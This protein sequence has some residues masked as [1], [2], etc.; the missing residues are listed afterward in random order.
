VQRFSVS[1]SGAVRK[2]ASRLHPD[3]REYDFRASGMVVEPTADVLT[4]AAVDVRCAGHF[5]GWHFVDCTTQTSFIIKAAVNCLQE[6]CF[7]SSYKNATL[8]SS[9][10]RGLNFLHQYGPAAT[11]AGLGAVGSACTPGI[12]LVLFG[13]RNRTF[14]PHLGAVA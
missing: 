1:R 5:A 8:T 9:K 10:F 3:W 14:G 6:T 2:W 7:R 4:I 13:I 11:P 12:Q